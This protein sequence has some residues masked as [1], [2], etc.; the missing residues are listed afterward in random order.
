LKE[1]I[2]TN[3]DIEA[4]KEELEKKRKFYYDQKTINSKLDNEVESYDQLICELS[5]TLNKEETNA[6]QLEDEVFSSLYNY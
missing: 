6:L 2:R 5:L 3:I 1:L 4:S